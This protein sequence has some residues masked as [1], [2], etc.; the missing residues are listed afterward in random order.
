MVVNDQKNFLKNQQQFSN[1]PVTERVAGQELC[2]QKFQQT[3]PF[4]KSKIIKS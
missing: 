1:G 4:F 2:Y 3:K